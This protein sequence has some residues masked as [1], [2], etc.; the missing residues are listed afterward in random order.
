MEKKISLL[1]NKSFVLTL[2][3]AYVYIYIG[4]RGDIKAELKT[5][6]SKNDNTS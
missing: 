4:G 6:I 1:K 3:H 5:K 2:M